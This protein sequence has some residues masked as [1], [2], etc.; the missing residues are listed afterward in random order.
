MQ[1]IEVSRRLAIWAVVG[2]CALSAAIGSSITLLAETGPPGMEGERGPP[3]PRGPE[4]PEGTVDAPDFGF[5]ETEIEDLAHELGDLGATEGRLEELEEDLT[6]VEEVVE[7]L[8][9]EEFGEP[10]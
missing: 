4:G 2:V 9:A 7:E 6:D 1:T 8:C 3:G 5:L 10:C